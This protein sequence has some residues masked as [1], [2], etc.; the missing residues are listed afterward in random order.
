M[1]GCLMR[2]VRCLR[3]VGVDNMRG[4]DRL[5]AGYW[6]SYMRASCALVGLLMGAFEDVATKTPW[7]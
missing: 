2:T 3:G 4:V 6:R 5:R 7:Y 1:T